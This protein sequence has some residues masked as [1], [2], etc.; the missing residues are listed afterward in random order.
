[1]TQRNVFGSPGQA[2]MRINFFYA[3]AVAKVHKIRTVLNTTGPTYQVETSRHQAFGNIL[4]QESFGRPILQFAPVLCHQCG[5]ANT[6]QTIVFTPLTQ[7]SECL[8]VALIAE[9]TL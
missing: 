3:L 5:V 7:I 9:R 4:S 8:Q 6:F 1:M 2:S